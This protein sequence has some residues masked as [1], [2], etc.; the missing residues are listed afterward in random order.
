MTNSGPFARFGDDLSTARHLSMYPAAA[1]GT[2]RTTPSS[3]CIGGQEV[4]TGLPGSGGAFRPLQRSAARTTNLLRTQ[5]TPMLGKAPELEKQK[6][7]AQC[8]ASMMLRRIY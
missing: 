7:D 3:R 4:G 2:L 6:N 5:S 1:V 8:V